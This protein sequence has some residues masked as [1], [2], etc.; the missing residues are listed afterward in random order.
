MSKQI[1][2]RV[3]EMRFD[4]K[5]FE[6]NVK[7][8]L[9]T[10]DRLK[11]ALRFPNAAKDLNAVSAAAKNVDLSSMAKA[12][13]AV[14]V[15]FSAM[16]TVAMTAISNITTSAMGMAKNLVS[17][18][19]IEPISAGFREYETQINAVQTILA[20]TQSKGTTINDVN[21]ALDELNE[22]ADKTIYNFA[23]MTQN[24]GRFTAAG[25]DLD[26][27]VGAIKGIAN[28]G[29]MS[30]STAAQVSSAMYQ[31]SQALA[32]GRV[33]LMDWNSVVNAGMGGEQFQNALKRT[34]ENFGYDVDSMIEKYGSF[35][36]SLTRGGW[37]TAEVLEET[38]N[39][40]SGAY[41]EAD[42]IA[43]GYTE[44]QAAEILKMAQ[45]AE[46]AATKVKS[47][48]Q[49]MQTL[50]EAAG[51]GWAQSFRIILGDFEEAREFFTDLS[52]YLGDM[53]NA[54]SE[55]RNSLLSGAFDSN[56]QRLTDL[57]SGVG[58]PLNTF[59]EKIK[60]VANEHGI[61]IDRMVE[62][63]GSFNKVM[64]SG[65]I[66]SD[67][68]VEAIKRIAG[69][70]EELNGSTSAMTDKLEHFQK[71]VDEVWAGEWK[72]APERYQ[73]LADAG[74]DY[75]EVQRLVNLTEDGRRLTL[76]DLNETELKAIGYTDEQTAALKQLA[77]QAEQTGTPLNEL[78][79][80][81]E[82]PSG[83]QLFLDSLL[84]IV[85]AFFEPLKA[86]RQ[87]FHEVFGISSEDLYNIIDGFH[88]LTET[89]VMSEETANNLKNT[90]KGVLSVF[91]IFTTLFGG[92]FGLIFN[93]LVGFL[94]NFRPNDILA[95]TGAI[96][97]MISIFVDAATSGEFLFAVL[98]KL[99][100][101]LGVVIDPIQDFFSG[102]GEIQ[103]VKDASEA[104]RQFFDPLFD[105]IDQLRTLNPADA[106]AKVTSDIKG[107]FANMSWEGFLSGVSGI[108]E[109][110][111]E[112]FSRI[113]EAAKTVGPD[114]I[115]GLQNGL[116]SGVSGLFQTMSEIG[117]RILEA[118]KAVLGIHSPSTETFEV[119]QNIIQGLING[120]QSAL[121]SLWT[122]LQDIGSKIV[123]TFSGVDWGTLFVAAIGIAGFAGF[124]K[125][126]STIGK[127]LDVISG[128]FE[129]LGEII[130]NLATAVESVDK[131]IKAKSFETKTNAILNLA[132]AIALLAASVT[133]LSLMDVGK[134]W[135]SVAAILA[136]AGILAIL[137]AAM[138][139]LVEFE[140]FDA[141]KVMGVITSL[142]TAML[143]LSIALKIMSTI[144]SNGAM[145]AIALLGSV[146]VIIALMVSAVQWGG[147]KIEDAGRI[148]TRLG[149][150]FIALAVALRLLGGMDPVQ[151]TVGVSIMM[152][153][154]AIM[155]AMVL[156]A[157]FGGKG[158]DKVGSVFTKLAIA[159]GILAIVIRLIGGMD[160][161][162]LAVGMSVITLFGALM[163]AF[164]LVT[165]FAG[166]NVG[167]A[168]TALLSVSAAIGILAL[169]VKLIAGTPWNE[170]AK[171]IV[172]IGVLSAF[173]AGLMIVARVAGGKDMKT[174]GPSLLM[175]SAS[176]GILAGI[177][178][179]LGMVDPGK[180][181]QGVIFV[182]ILSAMMAGLMFVSKYTSTAQASVIAMA[183][184]IGVL[185]AGLVI[186][187]NLDT[188]KVLI[189]TASISVVLGSLALVF[190]ASK[191]IGNQMA[192]AIAM[193]ATIAVLVAGLAILAN[194][195]P[196]NVLRSAQSLSL[197]LGTLTIAM[198]AAGSIKSVSGAALVA[199][200]SMVAVMAL[201]AIVLGLLAAL[202][203]NLSFENA[204]SLSLVL[205]TFAGIT[206]LLSV[207]GIGAGAAAAGA[208][209]MAA[210]IAILSALVVALGVLFK[211]F[212]E[213]EGYIDAA[214][215][216]MGKIGTAI[217]TFVGSIVGGV[218]EG[219][220]DAITN[221]LPMLA[222]KLSEFMT[223][224]GPFISGAQSLSGVDFSGVGNLVIAILEIAAAQF[225]QGILD[226]LGAGLDFEK[227]KNDLILLADGMV[228]FSDKVKNIDN[229]SVTAAG[230]AMQGI[231]SL[232]SQ[233]GTEGG[234]L[235]FF[236]GDKESLG[237]F[238]EQLPLLG[239]AISSYSQSVS[240]IDTSGVSASVE[241]GKQIASL[242]GE[243]QTNG[244][245]LSAIF[246]DKE[247][248][249]EFSESIVSFA[250]AIVGYCSKVSG[251][252]TSGVS[253]SVEAGKQI[254]DLA[255]ALPQ[256]SG[257]WGN[258]FGGSS[259]LS[260]F[261]TQITGFASAITGYANN[262][263]GVDFG[264]VS[265]SI[266]Y[267]KMLVSM[268]KENAES[269]D[270]IKAGAD[271][272]DMMPSVGYSLQRYAN[273]T[274]ELDLGSIS[275]SI[276][277]I[278][279]LI[280]LLKGMSGLTPDGAIAFQTA[281]ETISSTSISGITAAF[282]GAAS[283]L[284][285]IGTTLMQSLANG[286]M[287]GVAH[288]IPAVQSVTKSSLAVFPSFY[289]QFRESGMQLAKNLADGIS[290]GKT[291]V[292]LS[293]GSLLS[294]ARSIL[295]SYYSTFYSAGRYL[296]QGLANGMRDNSWISSAAAR[297][298]AADA[299]Q[300]ARD[301]LGVESP[302]KVGIEIGKYF[303]QGLGLGIERNVKLVSA[304]SE[305]AG[306]TAI[307]AMR[308]AIS[309]ISSVMNSDLDYNPT[310]S[311]V[312]DLSNVQRGAVRAN[313]MLGNLVSGSTVRDINVVGRLTDAKIQNGSIE[314]LE[315]K[316]SELDSRFSEL[317][318]SMSVLA[319][320]P[321]DELSMYVDGK[322]L[323]S[324]IAKPM[325]RQ[326]GTI[327]R[328]G[329]LAR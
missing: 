16:Q 260:T 213:L 73:L 208:A 109:R 321:P 28:L 229:S 327:S 116:S 171:G 178:V 39:Q 224:L 67:I 30:G 80:N 192:T 252:D 112:I 283:Q 324:S 259:D 144:D 254:A 220:M 6:A 242:S 195:N 79:A 276:S 131:Y 185:V 326:L 292:T 19:T 317:N 50:N 115:A 247:T 93:V 151:A 234:L 110:I 135:S 302:S 294:G 101:V 1:D 143:A 27:S 172:G 11:A 45:T 85:K 98:S 319:N 114:I 266:S 316:F 270:T 111:G 41:T 263:L 253:A 25:V 189:A 282:S 322:K 24:I 29:A 12:A 235:S 275:N 170:L 182:G 238:A 84:N 168:G 237:Q 96:G 42:L 297:K 296:V 54:Q 142:G 4:N 138:A 264:G 215:P 227:F 219:A 2:E 318:E 56:W 257:W 76:E 61:A 81:L 97:E 280:G 198:I 291:F 64:E 231:A 121:G 181:A 63:Q 228:S 125:V 3:V 177:A 55:A 175:I 245:A 225:I 169:T 223:N 320:R 132:K 77:R 313:A 83:R 222:Q 217:G 328:R 139:K 74:Y 9:G 244:G 301:E 314:R 287:I 203:L 57:I 136:L 48:T 66:S 164:V 274:K 49:L 148:F 307:D 70:T 289:G 46:D 218:I 155:T 128:P 299:E 154:G 312:V 31:L 199:M 205:A 86:L 273:Y 158:I 311:P 20:N 162:E 68:I 255:G 117:T 10:L 90:F 8:S 249:S 147:N 91:K 13:D 300:A 137:T 159:F 130:G 304:A 233:M 183:A 165:S 239:D 92:A 277:V 295:E 102:F 89:L 7:T 179:L 22:Y 196:D 141:L 113:V 323:A 122:T 105:Y 120:I 129:G 265:N 124:L 140:G 325:N 37:L 59:E 33:S 149:I 52:E 118:I 315:S 246:G 95:V 15:K 214:I 305:N 180:L 308:T 69:S 94:E 106:I 329:A 153:V 216:V 21:A 152:A 212:P 65:A 36:E 210:V 145:T 51:S 43:K 258:V 190:V 75:A 194:F 240:G 78:I 53:I 71:V 293:S 206:A 104:I 60:E 107:V 88:R 160:P 230:V 17:Q 250:E 191:K 269:G 243:L 82:K 268:L 207:I 204:A 279:Q 286:M 99:K 127:A 241:A 261:S 134:V 18:F 126:L 156:V 157:S 58:V 310:I 306:S 271:A 236:T 232:M 26:K 184:T 281:I 272:I 193:G 23:E 166:K 188:E 298:V 285:S 284:A 72:N 87:A 209:G 251:I 290:S 288:V 221:T 40:I 150:A 163:T 174:L 146:G 62:E 47:F 267:A 44:D 34:A 103:A 35:R 278:E 161:S 32:A 38:L 123:E 187:S 133:V 256:D 167:K 211:S 176:I 14:S 173:M 5:D 197:V 202:D 186:L 108:G 119:G 100:E 262:V 303:D 201:V 248:L 309:G 226:F 200:G